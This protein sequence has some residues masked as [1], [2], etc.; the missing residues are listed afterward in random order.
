LNIDRKF[1]GVWIPSELWLDRDL[2]ITE[3]VMMVEIE[4]LEDDVRGCY[5]SNA[6]FAAFFGL[7]NSRV[8]E[9]ISGLSE[10]GFVSVELIREGKRVVERRIRLSTPFDKPNTPSEKASNPFGKGFEPPSENT[11]GSNTILGNTNKGKTIGQEE[12]V[13]EPVCPTQA[14]VIKDV[15][16][17]WRLAM[18]SPRSKMDD[19]RRKLIVKAL[20]MYAVEDLKRA[21]DGC[22]VSPF[23][24]GAND[25]KEKYNGLHLIFRNAEKID[26]FIAKADQPPVAPK[27]SPVNQDFASKEYKGTANDDFAD[28]LKDDE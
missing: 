8:S 2:S 11:Q 15:F 14:I 10:K 7:S 27:Q 6:H 17:H 20:G 16:D 26:G 24:M 28:F 4:S 13:T 21:I 25:R 5:A 19:N 18:N 23:H 12:V 3:K 22:A 9:I 1:K